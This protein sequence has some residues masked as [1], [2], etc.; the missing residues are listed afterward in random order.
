MAGPWETDLVFTRQDG[1]PIH[2]ER[3]SRTFDRHVRE[4]GL[5]RIPLKNLRHSHGTQLLGAGVDIRIVSGR[6]GHSSIAVTADIY[7]AFTE[8]MDQQAAEAGSAALFGP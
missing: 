5:P 7:A 3:F 2:P 1:S 4:A 8:Q 6:L